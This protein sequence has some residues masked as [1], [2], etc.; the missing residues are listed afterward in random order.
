MEAQAADD[1]RAEDLRKTVLLALV[2]AQDHGM[3][4]VQSRKLTI[5]RFSVSDAQLREIE[6]EGLDRHWPPL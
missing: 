2:E 4:V 1:Q 6:R 3:D 5:E